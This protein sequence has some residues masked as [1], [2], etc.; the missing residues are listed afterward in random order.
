MPASILLL[1]PLLP[2]IGFLIN[3][4]GFKRIPKNLAGLLSVAAALGSFI[5]SVY[6][7]NLFQDGNGEAVIAH[8]FDWISVGALAI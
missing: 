7:F 8:Y 3:G 5:L 2:F 1:I 4:I 6:I